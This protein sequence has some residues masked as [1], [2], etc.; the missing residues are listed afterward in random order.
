[1]EF[2]GYAALSLCYFDLRIL[3]HG[4][5]RFLESGEMVVADHGY[6]GN[7]VP[8]TKNIICT[9]CFRARHTSLNRKLKFLSIFKDRFR[10]QKGK[11]GLCFL[12]VVQIVQPSFEYGSDLLSSFE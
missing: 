11:H 4:L 2:A 8:T 5:R 12:A 3:K 1:M 9:R 6:H 7:S 10:H